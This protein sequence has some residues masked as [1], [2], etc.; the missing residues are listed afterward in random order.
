MTDEWKEPS[1][2]FTLT[3]ARDLVYKNGFPRHYVS[4]EDMAKI[5]FPKDI[6]SLEIDDLTQAMADWTAVINYADTYSTECEIEKAAKTNQFNFEKAK[7]WIYLRGQ[8]RSE[9]DTR[10]GVEKLPTVIKAKQDMEL[11]VAK[12]KLAES[13]LKGYINNYKML[14][15]ELTKRGIIVPGEGRGQ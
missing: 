14:S 6:K 3:K 2:S 10:K 12:S 11:A 7:Q 9:E 4:P 8:G 13:L 5:E 1:E 15:R